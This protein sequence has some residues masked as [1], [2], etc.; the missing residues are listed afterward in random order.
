MAHTLGF[1]TLS[2][3]EVV[4]IAKKYKAEI[5]PDRQIRWSDTRLWMKLRHHQPSVMDALILEHACT[6]GPSYLDAASTATGWSYP[7]IRGFLEIMLTGRP[8]QTTPMD[9]DLRNYWQG[10]LMGLLVYTRLRC[11]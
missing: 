1:Q 10:V 6:I 3:P 7:T 9:R 8:Y 11:H 2:V 4:R 5:T